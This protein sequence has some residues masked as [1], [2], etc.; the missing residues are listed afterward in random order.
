MRH[1]RSY[2]C[3]TDREIRDFSR[4]R[5]VDWRSFGWVRWRFDDTCAGR[6][7]EAVWTI[8]FVGNWLLNFAG[9]RECATGLGR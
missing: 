1:T 4:K 6:R 9:E 2:R 3:D 8:E 5:G 7:D